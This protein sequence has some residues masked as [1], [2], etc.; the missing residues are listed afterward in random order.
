MVLEEGDSIGKVYYHRTTFISR[1]YNPSFKDNAKR[2]PADYCFDS[3]WYFCFVFFLK[4]IFFS[5]L[6][7]HGYQITILSSEGSLFCLHLPFA[8]M[9]H[10]PLLLAFFNLI[11]EALKQLILGISRNIQIFIWW[12]YILKGIAFQLFVFI[13][14]FSSFLFWFRWL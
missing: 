9:K 8:T 6:P 3:N 14:N 11:W 13:F 10:E 1:F 4:T 2:N 12:D 5:P 7:V